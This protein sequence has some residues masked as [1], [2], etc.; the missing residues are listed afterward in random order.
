MNSDTIFRIIFFA[1]FACSIFIRGYYGR[2]VKQAGERCISMDKEAKKREG[3]S[4]I[5]LRIVVVFLFAAMIIYSINPVW[6]MLFALPFPVWLRWIGVG[7]GLLSF[8]LM[9][10]VHR[11]LGKYWSKS[12]E[13]RK[14]HILITCGPYHWI[15]HPMY[16]VLS[17][18]MIAIA[19]VSASLPIVVL[20]ISVIII[21]YARTVKEEQMMIDRFGEEYLAYM[22]RTGRLLPGLIR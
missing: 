4:G 11:T 3:G 13:L 20:T 19:L 22:K 21:L 14:E 7:L 17:L 16:A 15:R 2:K 12:L 5:I 8:P 1:L 9:I 18:F 6:A 10:W